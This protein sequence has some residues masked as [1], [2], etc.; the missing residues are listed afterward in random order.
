MMHIMKPDSN[1][2]R[3]SLTRRVFY[4][5]FATAVFFLLATLILLTLERR[6]IITTQRP[7]DLVAYPPV[8]FIKLQKGE[9]GP[10]VHFDDP[11][12]V[13]FPFPA[14]KAPGTIRIF[15]AGESFAMGSPYLT[16]NSR[17]P[18]G[19]DLPGWLEAIMKDRFPSM[20]FEV[21]CAAAG[22]QNSARV[23]A[24]VES[25]VRLEPDIIVTATGNNEGF[26][27]V[28]SLNENLHLWILYRLMKKT[29]LH[30]PEFSE[31]PL[32]S[33]QDP[34]NERLRKY[35]QD[36][37]RGIDKATRQHG[38]RL[39]LCTMPINLKFYLTDPKS[40]LNDDPVIVRAR[41]LQSRGR[42]PEALDLYRQSA[43]LTFCLRYIAGCYEGMGHYEEATVYY[44]LAVEQAPRQ[45]TRP[46]F[47]KF[48]RAFTSENRVPLADLETAMERI[49]PH[50]IP[51]A[52]Q[53]LDPCHLTWKGYYEMAGE[54]SNTLAKLDPFPVWA[55]NIPSA[56]N[57]IRKYN[58][59]RL[60]DPSF[61]EGTRRRL[62]AATSNSPPNDWK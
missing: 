61:N 16:Q 12:M 47:N 24:I 22:A 41:E 62:L 21:I 55:G 26:V 2:P 6:K 36:N 54:I 5:M 8:D 9:N 31:R 32:F 59:N 7:D 48:L 39:V 19:G 27:P 1:R 20:R 38:V 25:L 18:E 49:S 23:L 42:Y 45:Q 57:L 34:N 53:F 60:M 37:I 51:T 4:S 3:L 40:P 50:G 33:P 56:D 13:S 29:L 43:N 58:W 14:K 17:T 46:S 44:R 30:F 28:T 52:E 10:M 35:F 11:F 15:I